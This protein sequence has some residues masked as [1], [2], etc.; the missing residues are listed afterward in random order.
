MFAVKI[1]VTIIALQMLHNSHSFPHGGLSDLGTFMGIANG[2]LSLVSK[3]TR[4]T[5]EDSP[6]RQADTVPYI[7]VLNFG[8][9][10]PDE[11]RTPPVNCSTN[12]AR[13]TFKELV[14][15]NK[16]VQSMDSMY[17]NINERLNEITLDT[18]R[19]KRS[20]PTQ[21]DQDGM[22]PG[23]ERAKRSQET[24][25]LTDSTTKSKFFPEY[26]VAYH[27]FASLYPGLRRTF[28]HIRIEIPSSPPYVQ[29]QPLNRLD[30]IDMYER[31]RLLS[32]MVTEK[33]YINVVL[34][35]V[36]GRP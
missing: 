13:K 15:I 36:H 32:N 7:D 6:P 29:L 30:C 14:F 18:G 34:P 2:L 5:K 25:V 23:K 10:K 9:I 26:G 31:L 3:Q 19:A 12:C 11:S 16:L 20:T 8:E 1:L 33:G 35:Q 17:G 4:T 27:H 22:A 28:L 24:T 21:N